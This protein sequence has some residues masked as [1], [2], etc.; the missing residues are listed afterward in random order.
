MKLLKISILLGI[1]AI[2]GCSSS[3][4]LSE[5]AKKAPAHAPAAAIASSADKV[6][7]E[8]W[9]SY[10]PRQDAAAI[11]HMRQNADSGEALYEVY[12]DLTV[13]DIHNHDAADPNAIDKWGQ[14]GIDRTVLFGDIS[15]P[16]AQTTDQLA[17]EQ[18]RRSPARIYPSFAGFPMYEKEGLT[19]VK[20]N[21]EQGYLNIG[22]VVAASTN[23]PVVSKVAW[24]AEHP[25]DGNLPKIYDLAAQYQVPILLHID[26]LSGEPIMHLEEALDQH[27]NTA[28]IL[29]H[30]NAY[31][32][33]ANIESLLT[34]HAN[35]YIDFFAGFTAYNSESTYA[36]ADYAPLIEKYPDKFML[37]TDSGYGITAEEAANAL[38]EIIDLLTPET[39][40]KVAHQN[41]ERLI[42]QQPPTESQIRLIKTL[43]AK[44]GKFQTYRLNKRMANELIFQLTAA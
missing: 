22:E 27:P 15:E 29:G 10:A 5:H 12:R 19:I 2:S 16:S 24:K 44:A 36:L 18:Y 40:L 8:P 17:W 32:A 13:I 30:A 7:V 41:Y 1:A 35:L 20:E 4:S 9:T 34:K 3:E 21:L 26:P 38:Y 28:I 43:S 33:P 25:N 42:E 11:E 31:N 39:A 23:S 37:S 14:F 6:T